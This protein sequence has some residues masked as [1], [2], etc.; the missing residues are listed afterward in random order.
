[1]CGLETFWDEYANKEKGGRFSL[2]CANK[3]PNMVDS[4]PGEQRNYLLICCAH[5]LTPGHYYFSVYV[6]THRWLLLMGIYIYFWVLIFT[7]GHC[8]FQWMTLFLVGGHFWEHI[9][10]T[11][12]ITSLLSA[13]IHGWAL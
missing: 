7:H 12:C 4:L 11:G 13:Y 9:T 1:L 8:F 10:T 6:I 5:S 2:Y 3:L